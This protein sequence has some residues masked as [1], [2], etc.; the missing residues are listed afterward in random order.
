MVLQLLA[1]SI[2]F[3]FKKFL[4]LLFTEYLLNK[5][6]INN[7]DVIAEGRKLI[8]KD[9]VKIW[10]DK[11][12]NDDGYISKECVEKS[13][14]ITGINNKLDGKEDQ[15]FDRCD[16]IN[17]LLDTEKNNNINPNELNEENDESE[18]SIQVLK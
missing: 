18:D 7:K 12:D 4:K 6:D 14:L 8:V 1:R 11:Q 9:I 5:K 10:Y 2:N 17:N 3:S 16:V 15:F 13:F